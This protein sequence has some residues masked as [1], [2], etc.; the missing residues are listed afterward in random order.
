MLEEAIVFESPE[1]GYS[2][3]MQWQWIG[4]EW[5]RGVVTQISDT[6]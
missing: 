3:F 4:R 2:N 1:H 6:N 5:S